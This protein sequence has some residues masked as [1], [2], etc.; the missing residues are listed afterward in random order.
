M[1]YMLKN[2][3]GGHL[4]QKYNIPLITQIPI[5]PQIAEACDKSLPL[6]NLLT[7]P[8]EKYLQ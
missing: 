8:L 3:S 6:T 5:T 7:L 1:S 4:S 2:N